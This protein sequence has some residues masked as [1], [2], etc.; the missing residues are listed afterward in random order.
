M[1]PFW[2]SVFGLLLVTVLYDV[3]EKHG[4]LLY[5]VCFCAT[6]QYVLIATS[7]TFAQKV[8]SKRFIL[9]HLQTY[10]LIGLWNS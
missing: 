5:D 2:R 4:V 3:F 1:A 7:D 10:P 8:I 9:Y 6:F